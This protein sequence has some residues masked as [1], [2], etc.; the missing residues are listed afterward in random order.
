MAFSTFFLSFSTYSYSGC[1]IA[2]VFKLSEEITY[3]ER[4][5]EKNVF[6]VCVRVCALAWCPKFTFS[7]L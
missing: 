4:L 7:S 1:V 5:L 6:G 2:T 3:Y